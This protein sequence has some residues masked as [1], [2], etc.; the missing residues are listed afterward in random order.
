MPRPGGLHDFRHGIGQIDRRRLRPH[1]SRRSTPSLFSSATTSTRG[2]DRGR[3]SAAPSPGRDWSKTADE[4]ACRTP[5]PLP[6]CTNAPS[7]QIGRCSAR[8]KDASSIL[9]YLPRCFSTS[10]VR[11]RRP[12]QAHHPHT[13]AA[14]ACCRKVRLKVPI[15]EHHF[16][17][18][19]P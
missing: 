11:A 12:R 7:L 8:Q 3:A 17:G 19:L 2:C 16:R 1:R 14:V 5:R 10:A 13:A 18:R 4:S 6:R 15:D 9:T